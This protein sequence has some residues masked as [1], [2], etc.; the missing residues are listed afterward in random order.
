MRRHHAVVTLVLMLFLGCQSVVA[1]YDV[2]VFGPKSVFRGYSA[3][4]RMQAKF[5]G[6]ASNLYFTHVSVPAGFSYHLS[7]N[8]YMPDCY[9]DAKGFFQYGGEAPVI[10]KLQPDGGVE[11]GDYEV[12]VTTEAGEVVHETTVAIQVKALPHVP[13]LPSP[14]VVPPIPKLRRWENSMTD[15]GAYWCNLVNKEPMAF[16]VETQVWYYDGA[17]VY[18]QI[19]D[20]TRDKRWSWCAIKIAQQYRDYVIAANGK[21]PAWRVF[22]HGLRL[23][24]ERTNDSRYRDAV[25]LLAKNSPFAALGGSLDPEAI[26]ENAYAAE[27][28]MNAERMGAPRDPRLERIMDFIFGY[29]EMAFESKQFPGHQ[30]F[31]DGLAAEAL[32]EYYDLTQDPRVLPALMIMCDWVWQRGWKN[33]QLVYN[34]EPLGPHCSEA[35]QKYITD[36]V[37][38][39]VP[40]FG[41]VWRQTQD[42]KYLKQ[43]DELFSHGLDT[44]ITYSGKIF[45]QNYRWSFDYVKWRKAAAA[46]AAALLS[47]AA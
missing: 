33:H 4:I 6:S 40:A 31:M 41:W 8:P 12:V 46:R 24:Y 27:A 35:C 15:L 47:H 20:Y 32:I 37:N 5:A 21:I 9:K 30:T 1:E 14:A 42:L 44:D 17:R 36:L 43:G 23:A 7:C 10:L 39:V 13:S 28:Y 34:A 38:L 22:T 19:A 18:F 3:H 25:M 26:R 29:F 2:V 11:P 16:G 45:S